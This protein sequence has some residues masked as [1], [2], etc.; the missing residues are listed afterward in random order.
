MTL[1]AE[2][3]V[4][5]MNTDSAIN[6]LLAGRVYPNLIPEG[7]PLPALQYQQISDV[8]VMAHTGFCNLQT[9]RYQVTFQAATYAAVRQLARAIKRRFNGYK[10][11]VGDLRIDRCVVEN[12]TD[13]YA[14]TAL[15]PGARMDILITHDEH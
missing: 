5:L 7:S 10:G 12:D 15:I 3:M 13:T 14:E 8:P 2:A 1:A 11:V 9:T 4:T 6:A